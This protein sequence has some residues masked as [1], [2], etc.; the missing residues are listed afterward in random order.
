MLELIHLY[1]RVHQSPL[2]CWS[3]DV[4]CPIPAIS[5]SASATLR[6]ARRRR[7]LETAGGGPRMLAVTIADE[8]SRLSQILAQQGSLGGGVIVGGARTRVALSQPFQHH[9]PLLVESIRPAP[10]P[11]GSSPRAPA[12]PST[13]TRRRH[14]RPGRTRRARQSTSVSSSG[15]ASR[16]ICST[17]SLNGSLMDRTPAVGGAH[18]AC[19]HR[20]DLPWSLKAAPPWSAPPFPGTSGCTA[21]R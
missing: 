7:D 19:A 9:R 18:A 11:C 16:A 13:R 2:A 4:V 10:A 20:P 15:T 1:G 8:V 12:P 14:W 3:G 17:N 21:D 6:R 5:P